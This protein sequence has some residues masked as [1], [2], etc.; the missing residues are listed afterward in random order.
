MPSFEANS[1]VSSRGPLILPGAGW[2]GGA[3]NARM[4]FE[5]DLKQKRVGGWCAATSENQW[6]QVDLGANKYISAV[7]TQ[8][9]HQLPAQAAESSGVHTTKFS[10][11]RSQ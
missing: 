11:T 7:G 9:K 4:Y 1:R 6:L 8:G 5:D 3:R 10:L 2:E